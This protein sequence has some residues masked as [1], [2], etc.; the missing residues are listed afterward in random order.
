MKRLVGLSLDSLQKKY[1]LF[2]ALTIARDAG[3]DSIEF[4]TSNGPLWD[5]QVSSSIFSQGDE[6]VVTYFTTLCGLC[7]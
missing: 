6:G 7:Q 1:G 2:A 4:S 3:A 5:Y